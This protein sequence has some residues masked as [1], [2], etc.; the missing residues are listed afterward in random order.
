MPNVSI[1]FGR[2]LCG[3]AP[4]HASPSTLMDIPM[5]TF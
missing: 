5:N 4:Q 2:I 1:R 3:G